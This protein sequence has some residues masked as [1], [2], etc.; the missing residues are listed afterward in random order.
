MSWPRTSSFEAFFSKAFERCNF[1]QHILFRVANS[2]TVTVPSFPGIIC[3]LPFIPKA[4]VMSMAQH[5]TLVCL[6]LPPLWFIVTF[7]R[8]YLLTVSQVL[9]FSW[10]LLGFSSCF[11]GS[12]WL[13]GLLRSWWKS[14]FVG[15]QIFSPISSVTMAKTLNIRPLMDW[16]Y[17]LWSWPCMRFLCLYYTQLWQANIE[18]LLPASINHWKCFIDLYI[19]F[20]MW[21]STDKGSGSR[22]LLGYKWKLI[23]CWH[24]SFCESDWHGNTAGV[25]VL[26]SK[27]SKK[28]KSKN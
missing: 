4:W 11:G 19:Q 26:D 8:T 17:H 10:A 25:L 28:H 1:I 15:L 12:L 21:A 14:N 22:V 5:L 13:W 23:T 2:C 9:T 3:F 6:I 16:F 20:W 24:S 18:T 27:K 7:S